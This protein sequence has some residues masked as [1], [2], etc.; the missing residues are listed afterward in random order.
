[1]KFI[2]S[3][4]I[5]E[6]SQISNFILK[7]RRLGAEMFHADRRTNITKLI[8]AI[9]NFA[10]APEG[11]SFPQRRHL[12]CFNAFVIKVLSTGPNK[13]FKLCWTTQLKL[14]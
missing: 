8:I 11:H 3:R 10:N 6:E 7:I 5:F 4:H 13:R 2:F 9:R 12:K 1:M 14:M